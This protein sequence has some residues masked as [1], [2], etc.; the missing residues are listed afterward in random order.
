MQK[1]SSYFDPHIIAAVLLCAVFAAAGCA[2]KTVRTAGPATGA[3]ADGKD[4]AGGS[5]YGDEGGLNDP[6][7]DVAEADIR[8][9]GFTDIP[10]L[11]PITFE[12]DRYT[13]TPDMRVTLKNN[14]Q[15]L[16]SH[17]ELQILVEGHCDERGTLG[18]N[19]ALGQ[20]R[21]KTVREYYIRLGVDGTAVGTISYGEEKPVCVESTDDC[22]R[23][24]RRAATLARN[25]HEGGDQAILPENAASE[26]RETR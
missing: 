18:Y 11:R 20:K 7:V 24:N 5:L 1:R 4:Y 19:L 23:Q 8:G 26:S 22:W 13:L 25:Q 15:Y 2:K 6:N 14:A 9:E 16:K 10:D 17:P 3:D 21:A 12:Y